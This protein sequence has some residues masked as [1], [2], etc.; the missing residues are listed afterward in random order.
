MFG[1]GKRDIELTPYLSLAVA[2][3][4]MVAAD[5][6]LADE[7]MGQLISM[8]GGDDAI[9][10][11]AVEYIK[12]NDDIEETVAKISEM[13]N[14][15]QKEVVVINLLDTLLADG[16]ADENEKELFFMF[17]NSFGFEQSQLEVFFDVI[18]KKNN[19]GVFN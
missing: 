9:V 4:Y 3:V 12:Q 6:S 2:S 15:E 7:E 5:G 14:S 1:F 10:Q 8:F 16:D 11:D 18:S 13:L 19:F 17:S